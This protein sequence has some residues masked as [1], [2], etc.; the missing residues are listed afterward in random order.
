MRNTAWLSLIRGARKGSAEIHS[1][2]DS[3]V[4][5]QCRAIHPG[6]R[7]IRQ[8]MDHRR[9][10]QNRPRGTGAIGVL[11]QSGR[12]TARHERAVNRTKIS[13]ARRARCRIG[14]SAAGQ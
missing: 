10:A 3:L 12:H 4:V 1:R 8:L 7:A 9:Y 11:P 6:S 5:A 2:L 14:L 13:I